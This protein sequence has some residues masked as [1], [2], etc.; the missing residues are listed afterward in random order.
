[1]AIYWPALILLI[2]QLDAVFVKEFIPYIN[3]YKFEKKNSWKKTS[4]Q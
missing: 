3:L 1:M 4:I 2:F